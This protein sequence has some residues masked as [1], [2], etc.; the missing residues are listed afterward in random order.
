MSDP[1]SYW[2]RIAREEALLN[3][4]G[5]AQP[6]D[7]MKLLSLIDAL[8]CKVESLERRCG[9]VPGRHAAPAATDASGGDLW[10]RSSY[11]PL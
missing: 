4:Y 1:S 8:E 3:R 7:A 2:M 9:L 11:H 5:L 6:P 10:H